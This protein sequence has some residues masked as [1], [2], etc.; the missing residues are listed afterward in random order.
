M[1]FKIGAGLALDGEK[2]YRQAI[3]NINKDMAV[4][5]S[6]MGK[7]SAAFA[8]NGDKIGGLSAKTEVYNKQITEQK[9]KIDTIR[10]ALEN[11][12]KEFGEN[13]NKTKNWQIALNKAEGELSKLE[14]GL[15][16]TT[17]EASKLAKVDFKSLSDGLNKV[18]EKATAAAKAFAP[19]SAAA[20]AA[21]AALGAM[22]VKAGKTADDLNTLSKQTGLSTD[23]LQKFAYASDLIDVST[24][25]LT[26]SLAKLTRNMATAKK[27][28]GDAAEAFKTLHVKVTGA[29]GQLRNNEDVFYD[30]INA[31]AKVRNE[32]ERDAIAMA[33]FGKSAQDLNP[34]ILG[35]ADA[36][37]KY[38]EEAQSKGLIISQEALDSAN[39]FNDYLDKI[40]ANL[41][42]SFFKAGTE[43]AKALTP[44]IEKL[45]KAFEGLATWIASLDGETIMLIGTTALVV[46]AI[47]PLLGAIGQIAFGLNQLI[48]LWPALAAAMSSPTLLIVAGITALVVALVEV[49]RQTKIFSQTFTGIFQGV[50]NFVNAIGKV[51]TDVF[52]KKIPEAFEKFK[53]FV[54]SL[55]DGILKAISDFFMS[56]ING[57][58]KAMETIWELITAPFRLIG[59]L[60]GGFFTELFSTTKSIGN[61]V[62]TTAKKFAAIN[63]LSSGL[64]SFFMPFP[65]M[66]AKGGVLSQGSAIVGE[67]GAELLTVKNGK[68]IVQPLTGTNAVSPAGGQ[69]NNY[70]FNVSPAS[71]QTVADLARTFEGARMAGRV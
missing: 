49:E 68:A 65:P 50:Y 28:T 25:T 35:G 67:A 14:K 24:D 7:V 32:T 60:F 38:G 23:T 58:A 45:A 1:A 18:G 11:S 8:A 13:D 69:S 54:K 53:K 31:L 48:V 55:F 42:A 22:A 20:G 39:E 71:I 47:T 3:S 52:T 70:Y 56:I 44:L 10:A 59:E 41:S 12:A 62:A 40:K 19:V 2:E 64:S 21:A 34:L 36:L 51:F 66:M 57:I 30:T 16:D 61:N 9:K 15:A 5:G 43:L 63:V 6:E 26:G 27:G 37:K 4:L 29:G 33:I 17:K 46:A